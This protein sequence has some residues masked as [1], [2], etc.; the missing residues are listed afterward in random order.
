AGLAADGERTPHVRIR[1]RLLHEDP[2]ASGQQRGRD[3][4]RRRRRSG[5]R[6]RTRG[7]RW[8]GPDGGG[9]G[10]RYD[11]PVIDAPRGQDDGGEKQYTESHERRTCA[12]AARTR[13]TRPRPLVPAAWADSSIAATTRA[14]SRAGANATTAGPAPDRA[15]P[16]APA[17]RAAAMMSSRPVT[18]WARAG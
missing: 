17:P 18:R 13:T 4:C 14:A 1:E 7:R 9:C 2:A 10:R 15:A 3:R 16:N 11:D 8:R 12:P 6:A 5:S